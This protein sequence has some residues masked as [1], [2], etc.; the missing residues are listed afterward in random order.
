MRTVLYSAEWTG[1]LAVGEAIVN[2]LCEE[3]KKRGLEYTIEYTEGF[4]DSADL[5]PG[6]LGP[7]DKFQSVLVEEEVFAKAA[8]V[9]DYV[10]QNRGRDLKEE[11]LRIAKAKKYVA[12]EDEY[13]EYSQ[14]LTET[15]GW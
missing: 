5:M 13:E 4:S 12:G 2:I 1:D 11:A 7:A 10:L 14:G 8:E 3:L 15:Y 9:R 6:R